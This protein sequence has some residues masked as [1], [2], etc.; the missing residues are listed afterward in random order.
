M[1]T[2]LSAKPITIK[3]IPVCPKSLIV[4]LDCQ[5]DKNES[6]EAYNKNAIAI[7]RINR[8]HIFLKLFTEIVYV[9]T[10]LKRL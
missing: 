10:L 8:P 3:I 7:N 5:F 6:T 1:Y 4:K 9:L 2:K